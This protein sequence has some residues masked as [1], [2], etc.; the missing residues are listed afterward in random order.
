TYAPSDAK[1][2]RQEAVSDTSIRLG[3]HSSEFSLMVTTSG[4]STFTD[5]IYVEI[6]LVLEGEGTFIYNERELRCRQGDIILIPASITSYEVDLQGRIVSAMV[7]D[8]A[9]A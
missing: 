8:G 2:V 5:R 6:V 3:V 4:H 1:K 7:G 9:D